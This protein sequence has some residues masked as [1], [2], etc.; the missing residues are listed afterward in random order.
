MWVR[1]ELVPPEQETPL[2]RTDGSLPFG[3]PW[4]P[5]PEGS[6]PPRVGTRLLLRSGSFQTPCTFPFARHRLSGILVLI[7]SSWGP[8][9]LLPKVLRLL[10]QD[11]STSP[12]KHHLT[13]LPLKMSLLVFCGLQGFLSW[14]LGASAIGGMVLTGVDIFLPSCGRSAGLAAREAGAGPRHS[15]ALWH[16]LVFLFALW[17]GD[18]RLPTGFRRRDRRHPPLSF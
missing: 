12:G 6:H 2:S 3:C 1:P 10:A 16:Q 17:D 13:P 4:S 15:A 7:S 18:R 14:P 8:A 5:V 9:E 11:P